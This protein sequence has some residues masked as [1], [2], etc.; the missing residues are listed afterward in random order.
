MLGRHEQVIPEVEAL[1][2]EYPYREQLAATLMLDLYRSERRA[3]APRVYGRVRRR[4]VD[5]LGIEPGE[6]LQDLEMRILDRDPDFS[7]RTNST[8]AALLRGARGYELHEQI[9]KTQFGTWFR[10]FLG[11]RN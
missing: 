8:P 6:Q 5:E 1:L 11:S 9:G 7:S 4:L 2:H 10:G 3:E